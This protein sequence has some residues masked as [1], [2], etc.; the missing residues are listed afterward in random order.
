MRKRYGGVAALDGVDLEIRP[1]ETVA[2]LGPNGAG[3]TTLLSVALGLVDPDAGT[4]SLLGGSPAATVGTG[5]VGALLQDGGLIDDVRVDE[6]VTAVAGMYPAPVPVHEVLTAAGLTEFATRRVHGLS[7]GQRQRVRFGLALAGDPR[8]LVLDEPTVGLDV[9]SRRALW[10]RVRERAALGH[11]VI[12]S[13]HYLAEA[14]DNAHRIV[15]LARGKVIADG[16]VARITSMVGDGEVRFRLDGADRQ[17]LN[18]LP[19]V[20]AVQVDGTAVTLT[21]GDPDATLRALFAAYDGVR[22]V[23]TAGADLET[24]FVR[25]TG[26]EL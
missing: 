12:F 18:R 1:G 16:D 23:R 11:T 26:G 6:L 21:T 24:A 19:G 7:G 9:E 2:V 13:T 4:A 25:L 17:A 5:R 10:R 3:K 14:A 22:G 8:L 15:L 20:H